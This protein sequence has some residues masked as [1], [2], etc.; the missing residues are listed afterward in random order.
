MLSAL[1]ARRPVFH[2]ERDFQV[3]FAWEVQKADPRMDVYLETRPA[4]GVHLDLAFERR[5]LDCYTAIE[6]KY[7]TALW[8]GRV[9]GQLYDLTDQ[10]A[11]DYGRYGVVKDIA[12]I[13]TFIRPRPGSNGAVVVL[14]NEERYWKLW[15]NSNA[16]DIAFHIGDGLVLEG[17]R[18]W[19]RP[20]AQA[21]YREALELSGR[22]EM[23]WS[24]FSTFGA[25]FRVRQLVIEVPGHPVPR[26]G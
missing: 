17:K 8:S 18:E 20:P 26:A 22:Y 25:E 9:E 5:D 11:Y 14:T 24:E 12:R 7:F 4:S 3:A 23:N 1:A 2:S 13:E 21:K 6:L 10:R 19:I 16:S 15:P